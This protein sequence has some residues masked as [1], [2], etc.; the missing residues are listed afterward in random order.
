MYCIDT[1]AL[2][3]MFNLFAAELFQDFNPLHAETSQE[4][5]GGSPYSFT[6]HVIF[7]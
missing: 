5:N 2:V 6:I 1:E 3:F 4:V 7:I